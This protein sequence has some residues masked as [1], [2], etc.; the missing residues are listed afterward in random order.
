MTIPELNLALHPLLC[1]LIA[2]RLVPVAILIPL[3]FSAQQSRRWSIALVVVLTLLIAP[4]CDWPS[5]LASEGIQAWLPRLGQELLLGLAL[6]FG[7]AFLLAGLQLLGAILAQ[8]SGVTWIDVADPTAAWQGDTAIQ[9]YFT[10]T[11]LSLL[12][13][14]G[15][16]RTMV[17]TLLESF[18]AA[19]PGRVIAVQDPQA[20]GCNLL[21]HS[22]QWGIRLSMPI[23]FCLMVTTGV[24]AVLTRA[25]PYLGALGTGIVV[26]L[27]VLMLVSSISLEAIATVSHTQ[28]MTGLEFL[29]GTW[30]G[31]GN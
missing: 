2:A 13:V 22:L 5:E 6:G 7:F 30:A 31:G 10:M 9:R 18:H 14:S 28:W 16:H 24:L 23:A 20:F 26:N 19:P 12:L 21:S 25:T 11:M 27:V 8:L 4:V 1:V 29:R 3:A 15:G 17:E